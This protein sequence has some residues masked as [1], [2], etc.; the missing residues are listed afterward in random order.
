MHYP[1]LVPPC[2][3]TTPITICLTDGIGEDGAPKVTRE[4][5]ARCNYQERQRSTLDAERRLIT[6]EATA[7]FTGD[8]I[9][10]VEHIEGTATVRGIERLIHRAARERNPDGTVNFTR[11]ELI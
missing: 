11:L 8:L 2:V 7:L 4:I 6:V 3:C 1:Q 9:P 10:D 5:T